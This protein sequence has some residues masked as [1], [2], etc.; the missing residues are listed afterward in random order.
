LCFLLGCLSLQFELN[1]A[2]GAP[3]AQQGICQEHAV[4]IWLIITKVE[5]R[6]FDF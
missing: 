4:L 6:I 2:C 5:E 3:L 1:R